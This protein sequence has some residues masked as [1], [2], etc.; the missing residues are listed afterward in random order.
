[1]KKEFNHNKFKYEVVSP[2]SPSSLELMYYK[3][4]HNADGIYLGCNEAFAKFLNLPMEEIIGHTDIEILGESTGA[5]VQALDR[6]LIAQKIAKKSQGWIRLQDGSSVLLSTSKS[7]IYN[8]AQEVIGLMGIS[9]NITDSYE[10]EKKLKVREEELINSNNLLHTII[11]TVPV[12]IFW[13]DLDLN[14]LGC[15]ELF[16]NDARK[17]D[18]SEIIGKSDY[19][20]SWKNEAEIYRADDRS[21]L[22]SQIPKLFFEEPQ[23]NS[24][25]E[26]M[27]LRTSKIPLYDSENKLF[28]LLGMYENIT[29][30]KISANK[31]KESQQHLQ[32]IIENEPECV[33]LVDPNGRL[34]TMNPA[35][36]AM[37]EAESLEV[38]QQQTLVNYMCKEWRTPFLE[39]HQKVM[40]GLNASLVFKIKGLK[41]TSRWLETNAVPMRD[42]D[43]D[44]TAL[45]GITRDITQRKKD[46]ENIIYLAN[47]DSLT[48]LPNRANLDTTLHNTLARAKRNTENFALM[49]LDI[50]NF[51]EINDNLGHDTGDKLLVEVSRCLTSILREEDTVARLGGDEFIILSPNTNANGAHEVAKKILKEIQNPR[52]I[53]DNTLSVTASI[54]I[55]IYPDD[56]EDKETLFK[57]ADTAMYRSKREGRNNYSFFTKEMQISSKR[58]LEL[59]HALRTAL[60]NNEL[61]L[62]YQPQISLHN[63]EVIGAETLLRWTHPEFGNISPAEFI[64][65]AENNGL[66]IEIG[67][68]VLRSATKQL[69][70]W[71]DEGIKPFVV[72]VNLSAIQFRH[73]NLP[74]SISEILKENSLEAKYLELELT[75]SVTAKDPHQAIEIINAINEIGV[76]IS[77]DDFGTGYSNLSHLK[78]FKIYKLKIDQSFVQDIKD[79]QEDRA[80]VSAIIN[81]SDALGL[82]TIAEGVETIEQLQYLRSQGCQEVQ[83]YYFSKPLVAED[84]ISFIKKS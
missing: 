31:L 17:K 8:A 84:F 40:Q 10:N 39:L 44:I 73:A 3:D 33:K 62:V 52:Y 13:K 47:Y 51:K 77:I 61:H 58:N 43:G 2:A 64:P 19:D 24:D 28:G 82:K 59:S 18:E 57:N 48:Q 22:D 37:L 15:N 67:E 23:T 42:A 55:G 46:E 69:Q 53:D 5:I 76:K 4:Y 75:E 56:G 41:G 54:G 71:I 79:D 11:N 14:F 60:N 70:I 30:A 78:K 26:E 74:E 38:A 81:M 32:A 83:G 80:I 45:L 36:L 63:Q 6:E 25:G 72:S 16:A 49:F 68:W 27:W 35:G 7:L 12:R 20:L 21:V 29:H 65:I 66:I 50:D 1:M 34:I 9:I